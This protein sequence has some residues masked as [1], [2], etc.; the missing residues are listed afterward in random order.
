LSLIILVNTSSLRNLFY[1]ERE[2][3]QVSEGF[4][5]ATLIMSVFI[6]I[7][8]ANY[9]GASVKERNKELGIMKAMGANT[10]VTL[11]LF[12]YEL[13]FISAIVLI[14][15]LPAANLVISVINGDILGTMMGEE[16][17]KLL[18]F[19]IL[20]VITSIFACIGFLTLSSLVPLANVIRKKPIDVFKT[21]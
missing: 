21:L 4:L 20:N 14:I 18:D 11:S 8:T 5:L 9:I 17:I 2:F 12:I 10:F 16:S 7:V 6:F 19:S 13:L 1:Q 15:S 3:K